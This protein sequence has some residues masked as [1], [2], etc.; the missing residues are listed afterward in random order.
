[1]KQQNKEALIAL[2]IILLLVLFIF[3]GLKESAKDNDWWTRALCREGIHQERTIYDVCI[4][5]GTEYRAK[6]ISAP[7]FAPA[8]RTSATIQGWQLK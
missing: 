1:M 3:L 2:F 4:I 6:F 8:K 5:N 7:P